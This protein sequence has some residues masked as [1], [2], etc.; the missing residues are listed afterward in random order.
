MDY[1]HDKSIRAVADGI[2]DGA[3]VD[4]LIYDLTMAQDASILG[5]IKVI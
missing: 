4:S 5:K 2:V 3:A 1:S